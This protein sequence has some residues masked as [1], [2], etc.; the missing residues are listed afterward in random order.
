[1]TDKKKMLSELEEINDEMAAYLKVMQHAD[2]ATFEAMVPYMDELF[3]K[4]CR[5]MGLP[6]DEIVRIERESETATPRQIADE[7]KRSKVLRQ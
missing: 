6:D 1:M 4:R 5:A 7:L 2:E 3:R